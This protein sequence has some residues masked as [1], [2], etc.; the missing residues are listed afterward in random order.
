MAAGSTATASSTARS[1]AAGPQAAAR[2]CHNRRRRTANQRAVDI[3]RPIYFFWP[4]RTSL[5][6]PALAASPRARVAARTPPLAQRTPTRV[7]VTSLL[8]WVRFRTDCT[9]FSAASDNILIATD[10]ARKT[11]TTTYNSSGLA[12]FVTHSNAASTRPSRHPA[13]RNSAVTGCRSGKPP[14]KSLRRHMM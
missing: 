9:R 13:L 3:T 4:K 6:A 14:R 1:V 2:L 10:R 7:R 8:E 12:V 5:L 11:V